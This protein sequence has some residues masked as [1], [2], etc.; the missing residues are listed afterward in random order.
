MRILYIKNKSCP[1]C[2]KKLVDRVVICPNNIYIPCLECKNCKVY[3][4][5]EEYYNLLN[6]LA[7]NNGRRIN[8]NVYKYQPIKQEKNESNKTSQIKNKVKKK[9]KPSIKNNKELR[10]KLNVKFDDI[11]SEKINLPDIKIDYNIVKKCIYF[12][13]KEC[14][15]YNDHCKPFSIKCKNKDILIKSKYNNR[16]KQNN[17]T[18][19]QHSNSSQYVT[20]IIL[21]YNKKCEYKQHHLIDTK[22]TIKI[23]S[24]NN[25]VIDITLPSVFCKECNQYIILKND[26]KS[27]KQKGILL[28]KVTDLTPE[29]ITKH[30]NSSYSGTESKVHRLGYNVIK[31]K[32]N[33]TYE[34]RK[35]ILANIIENYGIT[36]HEILSM[37]DT[38]ITRK[39]NIPNYADAV[40]KWQQDREF[41]KNYS[42]GDIPEVIIDK[43]VIGKRNK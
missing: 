25:K 34:Q 33:Y 3:L 1:F 16:S 9:K 4:Y 7:S 6:K 5:T 28:C 20:A 19:I 11:P 10:P 40:R 42:L 32:Y 38:N 27:A 23:L 22:A 21:S 2:K 37:L 29:Y 26:Y 14:I 15:Y 41:V 36:R 31:Q 39:I 12:K 13:N 17:E 43:V 30:K 8:Y 24:K 18:Q 35:I